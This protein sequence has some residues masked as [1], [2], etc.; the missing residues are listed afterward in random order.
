MQSPTRVLTLVCLSNNTLIK[1]NKDEDS[2]G[3]D[4]I[5]GFRGQ[6]AAGTFIQSRTAMKLSM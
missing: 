2:V 3:P 5:P 4:I 1:L 6:L